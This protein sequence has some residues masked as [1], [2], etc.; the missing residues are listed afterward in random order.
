MADRRMFSREIFESS[1]M[2]KLGRLNGE[3]AIYAQRIFMTLILKADDYGRG[4]L[5][6]EVVRKDAFISIPD[7]VG[8]KITLD[9]VNNWITQLTQGER[10]PLI[11]YGGNDERYYQL[12]GWDK[13]QRGGWQRAKSVL[14]VPVGWADDEQTDGGQVADRGQTGGG[15]PTKYKDKSKEKVKYKK[16]KEQP[17]TAYVEF[18]N[19][20]LPDNKFTDGL[21]VKQCEALG[22]L[23]EAY[24]ET[25]VFAVLK[26]GSEDSEKRGT[27]P[28][29]KAVFHSIERLRVSGNEKYKNMRSGYE[30]R[31]DSPGLTFKDEGVFAPGYTPY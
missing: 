26:W 27:F 13:Y 10:P 1:T 6:P 23:I 12:T 2:L 11:I 21:M 24:G 25:E 30:N 5:I 18:I 8:N 22:K 17:P 28:G 16:T 19:Q 14:P 4:K 31:S 9:M 29:W 15:Q 3:Y 20:I 7:E